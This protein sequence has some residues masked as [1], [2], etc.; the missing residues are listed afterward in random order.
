MDANHPR[1]RIDFLG[2]KTH[3]FEGDR[4][5][6]CAREQIIGRPDKNSAH[7]DSSL[8]RYASRNGSEDSIFGITLRTGYSRNL[9]ECVNSAGAP[10]W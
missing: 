10:P 2:D 7:K 5:Q 4:G 6:A 9:N 8:P 3:R 1:E